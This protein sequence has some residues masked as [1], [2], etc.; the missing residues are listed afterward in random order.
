MEETE[1]MVGTFKRHGTK[2]S[3][4]AGDIHLG[5]LAMSDLVLNVLATFAR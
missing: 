3:I 2:L 4:V 1:V 5:D